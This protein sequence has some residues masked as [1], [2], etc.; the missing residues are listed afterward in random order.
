MGG[1]C[2][3]FHEKN[4]RHTIYVERMTSMKKK[5][6]KRATSGLVISVPLA[7]LVTGSMGAST[8]A[9][10][11]TS[12][13]AM[14]LHVE[15]PL[16]TLTVGETHQMQLTQIQSDGSKVTPNSSEV[17]FASSDPQVATVSSTG[18]ISAKKSGQVT[19]TATDQGMKATSTITVMSQV[20]ANVPK[21]L[22][23]K[24][25]KWNLVWDDEF[26]GP[27]GA[28][29]DPYKWT[30]EI[31]NGQ[32]G[33]GNNELEYYT[34]STQN[35][36]LDGKGHLV[37]RALKQSMGGQNY[38]SA[39]LNSQNT[40]SWRY[41]MIQVRA[42]L[43]AGE[44]GIWPAIWMMPTNNVYGGW[45]SSGEIDMMEAID[46][47]M[48]NVYGT[49]HFGAYMT[50]G[51]GW[52]DYDP[53]RQGAY[54]L[55]TTGYHTYGIKWTPNQIQFFI[56]GHLY[57]TQDAKYWFSGNGQANAPFDQ[58]FHL[59]MNIAVGGNWPG[60]PNLSSFQPQQMS[61]DYVRV[62]QLPKNYAWPVPGRIN[63]AKYISSNQVTT[64]K[65]NDLSYVKG[66]TPTMNNNEPF[67]YDQSVIY[68]NHAQ[69]TYR[70]NVT[71]SG[72]YEMQYRVASV[73][74]KMRINV[75]SNNKTLSSVMVPST[76]TT[77][78]Y[79]TV[80]DPHWVTLKAGIQKWNLHVS[81][82]GLV[83]LH[84]LR[85]IP[86]G[87]RYVNDFEQLSSKWP[88]GTYTYGDASMTTG[89][90][91]GVYNAAGQ[92]IAPAYQGHYDAELAYHVGAS[93]AVSEW[94]DHP[95]QNLS[96]DSG[97]KVEVY[98]QDSGNTFQVNLEANGHELFQFV[99]PKHSTYTFKDDFTGWKTIV[100]P[101]KQ[102][103]KATN[104]P[105]PG[106][107]PSFA[108]PDLTN[109]YSIDILA[110]TP[111]SKGTIYVDALR[112]YDNNNP[113]Q[114]PAPVS[115]PP[116]SYQPIPGLINADQFGPESNV[117]VQTTNDTPGIGDGHN[118]G[119]IYAGSWVGYYV[120]VPSTGNYTVSYRVSNGSTNPGDIQFSE[121]GTLLATTTVLPTGSWTT[122]ST[123]SQ[124][125]H[126]TAG[127]HLI[128]LYTSKGNWNLHWLSLKSN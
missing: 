38:T 10:A 118:L 83:Q 106:S 84:W 80:T 20:P 63:A 117:V 72:T 70:V 100:L 22:F 101:F 57:A 23:I 91:D 102:L 53:Y 17:T 71:K 58:A 1:Y 29:P 124:K 67:T 114:E 68:G 90:S 48:Q 2:K 28:A 33:W 125:V 21:A 34:N 73:S 43:P 108:K 89:R 85:L 16:Y 3:R 113:N 122:W 47:R 127:K 121:D 24:G 59:I 69:T 54:T 6:F 60:N 12:Q 18:V 96:P 75:S 5:I 98:G 7:L 36:F 77:Q 32:N 66:I 62:Y 31:G 13:A 97:L 81:G 40:G 99:N 11:N 79:E 15:Q 30:Y 51:G 103:V 105:D 95:L 4:F 115:I 120:N 111:N 8:I 55:P 35:A 26:N 9:W 74:G 78:T 92:K 50:Y 41:G 88:M 65:A 94:Y 109:V 107:S 25:Q 76:G 52:S 27:Q 46:N 119:Y 104:Q 93:G 126:V 14:N 39:R 82:N 37:I 87:P 128:K 44:P 110:T 123:V 49:L 112:T 116:I 45:P 64:E 56:D 61:I 86:A 42:K 19:I